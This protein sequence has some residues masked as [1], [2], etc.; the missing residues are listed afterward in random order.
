MVKD[1]DEQP[2]KGTQEIRRAR[3]RKVPSTE[4]SVPLELGYRIRM[5]S[6]FMDMFTNLEAL[7]TPYYWEFYEGFITSGMISH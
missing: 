4:A 3:S 5:P 1:T 6:Q 7:Q 2:N